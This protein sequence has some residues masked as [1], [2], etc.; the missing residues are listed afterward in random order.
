MNKLYP[1][2]LTPV[3][4]NTLWGSFRLRDLFGKA[5]AGEKTGETWE[6]SAREGRMSVIENGIYS[7]MNLIDFLSKAGNSVVSDEYDGSGFPLLIKFIDAADRLSLQV[8]PND[9]YASRFGELGKNEMWYII[10]AEPGAEIIY[11]SADGV[12]D[13][14][15]RKALADGRFENIL[16][17]IKV[18]PDEVYFI[19]AGLV[20]AIGA[21]V[22]IAEIQQNSDLTYRLYDY[23]RRDDKGNLREL[24]ID[25]ALDVARNYT[26]SQIEAERFGGRINNEPRDDTLLAHCKYFK[27]NKYDICGSQKF[28]AGADSLNSLLILG[29]GGKIICDGVEHTVAAGDSWLIP[30]GTGEY[31][32][33]G[34]FSILLTS[35]K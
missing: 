12:T 27:V 34:E 32:A 8:H 26:S 6:L 25:K 17:H 9:D 7:G 15:F 16:K 23:G 20:H 28:T 13:E 21:G 31:I 19:P 4:V 14:K 1:L 5:G 29:G 2:K 22:L 35:L 18:K 24:H 30:A 11:G 3:P 10:D 33:S